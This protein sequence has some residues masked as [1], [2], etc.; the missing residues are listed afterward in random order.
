NICY[1]KDG[2]IDHPHNLTCHPTISEHDAQNKG[3]HHERVVQLRKMIDLL[4]HAS[5]CR[6]TH[7]QYLNF[8]KATKGAYLHCH[9][10]GHT[11][12]KHEA[13][14]RQKDDDEFGDPYS[15]VLQPLQM[16]SSQPPLN[17]GGRDSSRRFSDGGDWTIDVF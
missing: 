5:Q 8:Q 15:D 14:N 10:R 12:L 4:V 11:Q 3:A 1:Y 7:F 9:G 13:Q 6:S 17:G 2:G 16:T